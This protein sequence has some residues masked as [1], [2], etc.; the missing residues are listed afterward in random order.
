M[1]G[2][3]R[4]DSRRSPGSSTPR[5]APVCRARISISIRERTPVLVL[6]S[7]SARQLAAADGTVL[8]RA[9]KASSF[10]EVTVPEGVTLG[11][12]QIAAAAD[13]VAAMVPALRARVDSLSIARRRRRGDGGRWRHRGDVRTGER[14]HGEGPGPASHPRLRRRSR[15]GGC[16][17]ST[18]RPRRPRR[19]DSSARSSPPRCPIPRP[20]CRPPTRADGENEGA[21]RGTISVSLRSRE[22][23]S[24][25]TAGSNPRLDGPA[26]P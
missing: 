25:D 17:R 2:S 11:P 24:N 15:G 9:P 5:C 19:R 21:A 7:G 16:S 18:C 22:L 23:S 4:L 26:D 6:L 13:V 3:R 8:G 10:P 20:T 14:R 12:G 1:K